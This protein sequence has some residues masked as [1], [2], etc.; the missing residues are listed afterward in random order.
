MIQF[1]SKGVRIF[2]GKVKGEFRQHFVNDENREQ[3]RLELEKMFEK[4]K[5]NEK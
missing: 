4:L 2:T 3:T 5:E 1:S